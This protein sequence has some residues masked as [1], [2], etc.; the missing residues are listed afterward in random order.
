MALLSDKSGA[1]NLNKKA[2]N[3][4]LHV[5]FTVPYFFVRS[6]GSSAYRY[7]RSSWFHMYEGGGRQVSSFTFTL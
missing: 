3:F 6:S 4:S 1:T 2:K 7:G 5:L